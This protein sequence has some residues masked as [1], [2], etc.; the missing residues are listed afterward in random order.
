MQVHSMKN[1]LIATL[2]TPWIFLGSAF[3]QDEELRCPDGAPNLEGSELLVSVQGVTVGTPAFELALAS[4]LCGANVT[5]FLCDDAAALALRDD[6]LKKYGVPSPFRVKKK[7]FADLQASLEAFV[8]ARNEGFFPTG[9][10]V[11]Y[12]PIS[13]QKIY[14]KELS[15]WIDKFDPD[16]ADRPFGPDLL[17]VFFDHQR[18]ILDF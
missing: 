17:G 5:I 3:A 14:G 4:A 12:C 9:A 18:H 8:F 7:V 1:I 15:F 2:L 16:R 10:D 13:L 6:V 11:Y